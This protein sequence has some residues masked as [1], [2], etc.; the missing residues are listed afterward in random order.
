MTYVAAARAVADLVRRIPHDAWDGPGLG[1]WSMRD[2]VGHTSR[3]LVT[4]IE[5]FARPVEREE[6]A[7]PADYY[8][9][10]APLLAD[11][12]AVTERGRQ[13]GRDLGDDPVARFDALVGEAERV[14]AATDPDLVVHTIVGGMRVASYLPTRTFELVVHGMDIVHAAGLDVD[15][16]PEA[17]EEATVLAARVAVRTGRG[18]DVLL[19]LT[20]RGELGAGFSVV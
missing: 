4:V 10:T 12:E 20:G 19:A 18:Q 9:A 7:D 15:L 14:V 17:M 8:V 16:P 1:E 11:G 3:S 13:A 2:L 5:Y 6:L